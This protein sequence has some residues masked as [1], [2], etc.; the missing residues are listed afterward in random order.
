MDYLGSRHSDKGT[1]AFGG[2]LALPR[3]Q[4]DAIVLFWMEGKG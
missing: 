2:L 3:L 1:L 4:Q